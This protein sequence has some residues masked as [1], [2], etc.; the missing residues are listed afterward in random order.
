MK[1]G[2]GQEKAKELHKEKWR[3]EQDSEYVMPRKAE[4]PGTMEH[5]A[6]SVFIVHSTCTL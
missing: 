6:V 1:T 3:R 5:R 2:N 4:A